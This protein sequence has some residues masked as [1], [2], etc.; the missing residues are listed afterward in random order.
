V[1]KILRGDIMTNWKPDNWKE[2]CELT[3]GDK[4]NNPDFAQGVDVGTILLI[5]TLRTLGK[6]IES[7]GY[8]TEYINGDYGN[9]IGYR[10]V[11]DLDTMVAATRIFIPDDN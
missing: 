7:H 3:F 1:L 4:M 6:H 2:L 10:I 8:K 5:R 9:R 11:D